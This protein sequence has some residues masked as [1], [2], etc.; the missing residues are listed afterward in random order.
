VCWIRLAFANL[1]MNFFWHSSPQ[2]FNKKQVSLLDAV[3][4]ANPITTTT[5]D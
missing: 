5:R 4:L 3:T 1:L 2:L